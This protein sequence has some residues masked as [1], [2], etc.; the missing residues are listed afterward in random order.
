MTLEVKIDSEG[1]PRLKEKYSTL[2][3]IFLFGS[4]ALIGT[5]LGIA[6]FFFVDSCMDYLRSKAAKNKIHYNIQTTQPKSVNDG[7]QYKK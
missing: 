7:G 1:I 3:N 6:P 4:T 5:V 2:E